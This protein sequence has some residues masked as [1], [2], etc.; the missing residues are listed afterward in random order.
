MWIATGTRG[1]EGFIT[2]GVV[3]GRHRNGTTSISMKM[4]G[5]VSILHTVLRTQFERKQ[6]SRRLSRSLLGSSLFAT[7]ITEL[8]YPLAVREFW[9]VEERWQGVK[10]EHSD[11]SIVVK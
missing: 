4:W 3:S 9:A 10:P 7:V 2:T 5:H 8:L 1:R 6:R 11:T